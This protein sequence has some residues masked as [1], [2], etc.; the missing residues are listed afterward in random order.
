MA[1]ALDMYMR[2]L[3]NKHPDGVQCIVVFKSGGPAPGALRKSKD[4]HVGDDGSL[5]EHLSPGFIGDPKD[6]RTKQVML[7]SIFSA[8]AVD[9]IILSHDMEQPSIVTP[10]GSRG[11]LVIPGA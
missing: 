10:G 3:C 1:N 8:N 11:G 2:D 7:Q 6:P 5:Y 4:A 9:R